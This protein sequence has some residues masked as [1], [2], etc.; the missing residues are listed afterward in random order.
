MT[1]TDDVTPFLLDVQ[2]DS[3]DDL[4]QRLSTTRLPPALPGEDEW[5]LGPPVDYLFKVVQYW[6]D[7]YDWREQE[8]AINRW[9]QFTTVVNGTKIH[10][11]HK[12]SGR[13]DAVP[14]LLTHGWPGSFVEF[15][16]IIDSLTEPENDD[17]LA[18]D[19][20][21][22]SIPGFGFSQPVTR[23]WNARDIAEAWLE[24]MTRLDY[25]KFGVQG[26]DIGGVVSPIVGRLAPDR[27][28]GV[29]ANGG[30][31][32]Q[33]YGPIP[34]DVSQ[35]LTA[36]D[37]ER[38]EHVKNFEKTELGYSVIQSTRPQ[39]LAY[40]LTD[41]P[42]GV[43]GWIFD[44]FRGWTLPVTADPENVV[45]I[46]TLLTIVMTYWLPSAAGTAAYVGYHNNWGG[47]DLPNSV[48][49]TAG[50]ISAHDVGIKALAETRN[51]IVRWNELDFGG[52]FAALEY[53]GEL[54][55]DIRSFF[56]DIAPRH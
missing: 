13:A 49:P 39:A 17:D 2:Q 34:D 32:P 30:P 43:L 53:P 37:F 46:D 11:I 21:I 9:P 26:G 33:P 15:L 3:L 52:H 51:N 38:L 27:V 12:K 41:S 31:G 48:V 35:K 4:A 24:L 42:V 44:K 28:I 16:G 20:V 29:H 7:G 56:E 10:F 1:N 47:D 6:R 18:F 36:S 19:V 22:P 40:G 25:E 55:A 14:L 54:I 5:E 8:Q 50:L 23:A 45:P